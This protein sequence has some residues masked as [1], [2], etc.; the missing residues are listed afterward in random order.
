MA[1]TF[2]RASKVGRGL[3]EPTQ[4]VDLRTGAPGVMER[5][6]T[7]PSASLAEPFTSA[8]SLENEHGNIYLLKKVKRNSHRRKGGSLNCRG[9]GSVQAVQGHCYLLKPHNNPEKNASLSHFIREERKARLGE[10][11]GPRLHNC[12]GEAPGFDIEAENRFQSSNHP[13][14]SLPLSSPPWTL[15]P[16][17]GF[18]GLC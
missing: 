17:R 14:L 16:G 9:L 3:S 6:R 1:K 2:K 8:S 11:T 15:R 10:G 4:P 7:R 13:S 5:A 18:L 12:C